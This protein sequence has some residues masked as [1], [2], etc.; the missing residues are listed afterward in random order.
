MLDHIRKYHSTEID[1]TRSALRRCSG[2]LGTD[3][4][5]TESGKTQFFYRSVLLWLCRDML[6]F[7]VVS[8][9]GFIDFM[10]MNGFK[11]P[12]EIPD[13]STLSKACMDDVY[14]LVKKGVDEKVSIAPSTI[15]A[16][17]DM[18]TTKNGTIPFIT[19]LIRF[20]DKN[21]KPVTITLGT[22]QL[23]RPHTGAIIATRVNESLR[24]HKLDNRK[25]IF[26][27]DRGANII[28]AATELEARARIGCMNHC[29][30]S[31]F[32]TDIAREDH[33]VSALA[34]LQKVKRIHGA[35]AYQIYQLKKVFY[36]EQ[37]KDI[38]NYV[39][40]LH[41][42]VREA[43]ANEEFESSDDINAF[44][45]ESINTFRDEQPTFRTLARPVNTRWFSDHRMIKT[46]LI[47]EG[48]YF[49]HFSFSIVST[50]CLISLKFK[51]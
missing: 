7:S 32:T 41:D 20:L 33:F 12:E 10:S 31:I 14:I 46:F 9:K 51:F 25:L 50:N 8:G 44:V 16:S 4:P 11:N 47:S 43:I 23:D 17:C 38:A 18:S 28:R 30:H 15:V 6:P 19:I 29:V 5:G 40:L 36:Q 13:N 26:V 34:A 22:E 27:G 21:F 2:L 45:S 1:N 3:F 37:E 48:N 35:L 42:I 39:D 24:N 49:F